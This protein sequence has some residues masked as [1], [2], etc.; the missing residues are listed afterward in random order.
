MLAAQVLAKSVSLYAQD[1]GNDALELINPLMELGMVE[2]YMTHYGGKINNYRF[3]K[4][5]F[6]NNYFIKMSCFQRALEIVKKNKGNNSLLY[7]DISYEVGETLRLNGSN[8]SVKYLKDAYKVYKSQPIPSHEK[9]ALAL[10]SI[11]KYYFGDNSYRRAK[12][13]FLKSLT[14]FSAQPD[15]STKYVLLIHYLLADTY[16]ELHEPDNSAQQIAAIK[17]MNVANFNQDCLPIKNV[18]P[19]YPWSVLRHH[20]NGYVD[21]RFTVDT[22]GKLE[23]LK[24]I[25]Y[26]GSKLFIKAALKAAKQYRYIPRIVNGKPVVTEGKVKRI[27]FNSDK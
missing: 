16:D 5:V 8:S 26:E 1:Y 9:A 25:K 2:Y 14:E 24:V 21:L 17:H 10:F 13:Y 20:I 12:E 6:V 27:A 7:G 19:D 3:R 23:D 22:E 15:T 18:Q 11:G 4:R